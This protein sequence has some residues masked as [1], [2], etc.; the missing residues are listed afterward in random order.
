MALIKD[1]SGICGVSKSTVSKALRGYPDVGE[2]TRQ[3]ILRTARELDRH[4]EQESR[5]NEE[6]F[7]E[8]SVRL[9]NNIGVLLPD[10]DMKL[11]E[12]YYRAVMHGICKAA[13]ENG[14]DVSFLVSDGNGMRDMGYLAKILY[15]RM[16]G[17]CVLCTEKELYDRAMVE[18]IQSDVPVVLIGHNAEGA[19]SVQTDRR[20]SMQTLIEYLYRMGHRRIGFIR[21]D[22]RAELQ[23]ESYFLA[24]AALAGMD[25]KECRICTGAGRNNVPVT[26]PGILALQ[27]MN[28]K[29]PPTCI[30]LDSMEC[31]M[32]A[33]MYL[34]RKGIRVPEDISLAVCSLTDEQMPE[35]ARPGEKWSDYIRL[36]AVI[37]HPGIIGYEAGRRLISI[38]R[39]GLF[40]KK[41]A[42]SLRE[43]VRLTGELVLGNTVIAI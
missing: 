26:D 16:D 1:I 27:M 18:L 25:E 6:D 24:A 7:E 3:M 37:E 29:N 36:T 40:S 20:E 19:A 38:T 4:T 10:A 21:G 15:R 43:N 12:P 34:R 39:S 42:V 13:Q 35:N 17:V 22:S 14:C 8:E 23:M 11:D 9:T 32:A 5:K 2:E 41:Q 30:I 33:A 28:E 31:G